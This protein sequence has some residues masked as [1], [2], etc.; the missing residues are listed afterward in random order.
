MLRQFG[1]SLLIVLLIMKVIGVI[2]RGPS[3]LVLDA[4][5][6]WDL[7]GLVATGDVW[8]IGEAIAYRTPGYPWLIGVMR[9]WFPQPLLGLVCLQGAL[10]LGSVGLTALIARDLSGRRQSVGLVLGVSLAMLSSLTYTA[11]VLSETLFTFLLMAHLWSMC[12]F[13]RRP[14]LTGGVWVGLT[15]GLTIL[16]RPIG[17][18]IWVADAIFLVGRWHCFPAASTDSFCRRRGWVGA[19][20]AGVVALACLTPWLVRNERLF[21][22]VM[23][24]EFVGRN[25]WI[26]TFQDGSG[27]GLNW[28]RSSSSEQLE[29]QL[30]ESVWNDMVSDGS[31]RHTWTVSRALTASGLDDASADR[32]MKRVAKDAISDAPVTFVKKSLRR[33]I[34]FWRTRATDL[35][36]QF[37]ELSQQDI[38]AIAV[39]RGKEP[40]AGQDVWGIKVA[41]IDTALR[42]RWSNWLSGNTLLVFVMV[43]AVM[44]LLWHR[45]TRSAGLWLAALLGYVSGIT[46]ALEIPDYRYRMIVEPVVVVA[47]VS[48]VAPLLFSPEP[49]AASS[50]DA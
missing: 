34:N 15:L 35:P 10:W 16:T 29:N 48:A 43:A 9:A 14:A 7:G 22:R 36:P 38:A 18:L 41:P 2:A 33:W 47:V 31:W 12:R 4:R 49:N 28:P 32:L 13:V 11:A 8:L 26:V 37:A 30:T 6:Y 1:L 40:F 45:D 50:T 46:A 3:P 19:G 20:V 5:E 39:T 44:L 17:L 42:F 24:T 27:A 23:L 21:G 25:V